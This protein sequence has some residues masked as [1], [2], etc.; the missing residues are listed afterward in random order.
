MA[1]ATQRRM[2]R[3]PIL[4]L[5]V[6]FGFGMLREKSM[7]SRLEISLIWSPRFVGQQQQ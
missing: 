7:N 1:A 4:P 6:S 5:K 3:K 2:V